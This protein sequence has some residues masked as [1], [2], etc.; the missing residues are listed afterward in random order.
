MSRTVIDSHWLIFNATTF[1]LSGQL[2]VT[3]AEE[4]TASKG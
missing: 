2:A 1:W 4:H 3:K